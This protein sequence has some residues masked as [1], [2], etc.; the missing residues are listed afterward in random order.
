MWHVLEHVHRLHEYIEQIKNILKPNGVALIAVPNYTSDD[1]DH[2]GKYWAAYDVPR[3]LYHFSPKSVR[4]LMELH[5]MKVTSTKPMKLDAYYI[6]MLSEQ[7]QN[8]K[9]NLVAAAWHAFQSNLQAG[10]DKE[11]YSSLV[12]VVRK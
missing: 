5:G 3:H 6:A 1:A 12:Y 11:T 9:G 4:T 7:Y 2:Y 10:K 8:G